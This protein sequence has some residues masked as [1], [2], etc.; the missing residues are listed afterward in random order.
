[1]SG[2]NINK[3]NYDLIASGNAA[4]TGVLT[5]PASG[6]ENSAQAVTVPLVY[7]CVNT[8]NIPPDELAAWGECGIHPS[9]ENIS[10]N[11][12]T[13]SCSSTP[14]RDL[15]FTV[16]QTPVNTIGD[17]S[18]SGDI[19]DSYTGDDTD[20]VIPDGITTISDKVFSEKA[21][22][23]VIVPYSSL[24]IGSYAFANCSEMISFKG[25]TSQIFGPPP[26]AVMF[27]K[28]EMYAFANCVSLETIVLDPVGH[29]TIADYAFKDCTGL[30]SMRI[31]SYIGTKNA[32]DGC[33]N[34]EEIDI[35]GPVMAWEADFSFTDKLTAECLTDMISQLW[36]YSDG[37]QHVLTIGA[38][39][40]ARL[41]AEQIAAA[42]AKNW[43]I[44]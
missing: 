19:L 37:E 12:I 5:L 16:T 36:D 39:N 40:R 34:V 25:D 10:Q 4:V 28:I 9:E 21:I 20:I 2:Y 33:V 32:F 27:D 29:R 15:H 43:T 42:S 23:S 24:T 14:T 1:M 17:Y 3:E 31:D 7:F 8:I 13:F 38:T 44:V 41:T 26:D 35:I 22:T 18:G 6:W 11:S 30:I